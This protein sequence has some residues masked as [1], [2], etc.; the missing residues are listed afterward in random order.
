MC[1]RYPELAVCNQCDSCRSYF[2]SV[3]IFTQN[4]LPTLHFL[5]ALSSG[6]KSDINLDT[7]C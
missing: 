4:S 7:R 2:Y 1:Y 5:D 6:L 3:S